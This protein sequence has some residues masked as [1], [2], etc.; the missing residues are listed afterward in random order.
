M[1]IFKKNVIPAAPKISNQDKR[2]GYKAILKERVPQLYIL[3]YVISAIQMSLLAILSAILISVNLGMG[4][5][6]VA[7]FNI[8]RFIVG[9]T[10]MNIAIRRT[11]NRM[12]ENISLLILNILF[13]IALFGNQWIL[14]CLLIF[15]RSVIYSI[16]AISVD[17]EVH[18][19]YS[20]GRSSLLMGL[21]SSAEYI[22]YA[23]GALIAGLLLALNHIYLIAVAFAFMLAV[24]LVLY[25]LRK[26][27]RTRGL[28]YKQ[29]MVTNE[30]V[31]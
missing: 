3:Y 2:V 5:V 8:A 20:D 17:T 27:M 14:L 21:Q 31:C 13:I 11:V 7:I 24:T 22:G 25:F 23:I 4:D 30:D 15:N 1:F 19:L 16:F 26:E 29:R 10:I 12:T 9:A 28:Y 6:N 18:D